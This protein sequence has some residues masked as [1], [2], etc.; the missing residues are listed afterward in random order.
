MKY[1]GVTCPVCNQ[2]FDGDSDVVVCP[3]CGTP[4]H[5]DCYEKM[6]ACIN[7]KK[8]GTGFLWEN[9]NKPEINEEKKKPEVTVIPLTTPKEEMPKNG[10]IGER[11]ADGSQPF[12]RE[13]KGTEK[14]GNYTV[15]DYAKAVVKN[16]PK[17]MPRFL[18]FDKTK[19]K[20]SWNWAAFFFGPFYLA[21]RKMYKPAILALLL[22][23]LIPLICF[24][25][26]TEYYQDSFSKYSQVLT[27]EAFENASQMDQAM[28]E[29]EKDLP[30]QP[31]AIT[32]ASYVE[33]FVDVLCGIFANYLYFNHC[34]KLLDKAKD[35]EDRDEY[36]KK[37]GGRSIL[38][39]LVLIVAFYLIAMVIGII[40]HY[41]GT[42][43]A[44]VLR[45]FVK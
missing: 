22:I 18:M 13:I 31:F 32:A 44:T 12:F 5:R 8:H 25:E 10:V 38:G 20:T 11:P 1:D 4:H 30:P 23:F 34:T 2:V 26:V 42:D 9:P 28:T 43:L 7:E 6:G 15:D 17:F 19:R 33:M 45:K 40:Y 27:S 3:E 14:I 39:I 36:L 24:N 35:K 16:V 21:Y 29:F 41:I 37:R